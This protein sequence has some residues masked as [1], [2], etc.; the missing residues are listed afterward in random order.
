MD[1][2]VI[3]KSILW[4]TSFMAALCVVTLGLS[5]LCPNQSNQARLTS[6]N[7]L[8]VQ[9]GMC[10]DDVRIILGPPVAVGP[11]NA[12]DDT[13]TWSY[14]GERDNHSVSVDVFFRDGRVV[15]KDQY[16]LD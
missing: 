4:A 13:A 5:L 9:P 15:R 10:E 2:S 8:K 6:E 3:R 12:K 16:G 14:N 1:P 7:F 11:P